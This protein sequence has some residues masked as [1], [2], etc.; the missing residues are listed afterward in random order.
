M[1][2]MMDKELLVP[3]GGVSGNCRRVTFGWFWGKLGSEVRDVGV[4]GIAVAS[5]TVGEV[6]R[7]RGSEDEGEGAGEGCDG[8]RSRPNCRF[9]SRCCC[10]SE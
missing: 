6:T 2:G 3:V 7:R 1:L 5:E 8:R 4:G 10:E 9:L